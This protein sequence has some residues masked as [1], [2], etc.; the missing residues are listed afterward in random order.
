[1]GMKR[2]AGPPPPPPPP[3]PAPSVVATMVSQHQ[4]DD[5]GLRCSRCFSSATQARATEWKRTPCFKP[6]NING[7]YCRLPFKQKLHLAGGW[8]HETHQLKLCTRLN[9][10]FWGVCGSFSTKRKSAIQEPCSLKAT[11]TGAE[12]LRRIHS[13]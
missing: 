5:S 7:D 1:M 6:L 12:H 4:L 11:P 9:L 13:G 2:K 10:W 8:A 3:P